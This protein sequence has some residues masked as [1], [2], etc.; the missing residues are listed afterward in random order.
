VKAGVLQ[1][2]TIWPFPDKEVAAL[3]NGARMVVVPEMNYTGQVAGEVRKALGAGA[4]IRRVNKYN[5]T[6]I[7]PQDI[8]DVMMQPAVSGRSQT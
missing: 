3:G 6:I 2:Q 5:G 4:E 1:L 8:I 7:T